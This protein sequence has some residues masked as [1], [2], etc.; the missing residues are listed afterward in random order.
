MLISESSN[1][2]APVTA[3]PATEVPAKPQRRVFTAEQKRR[4]LSEIDHCQ[5]GGAGAILRREGLYSST[6]VR[7][8]K[9]LREA[10]E[11]RKRGRKASEATALRTQNERLERDNERLR[12]QLQQAEK[13]MEIQKKVSEILHITLPENDYQIEH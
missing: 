4:I 1:N 10:L 8:R 5:R 7:W 12:R 13:I 9:E 11:P 6:I 2:Q 3:V